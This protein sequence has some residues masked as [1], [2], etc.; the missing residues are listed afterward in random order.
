[1]DFFYTPY[2]GSEETLEETIRRIAA[3]KSPA[4]VINRQNNH[5]LFTSKTIFESYANEKYN[6]CNELNYTTALSI[7]DLAAVRLTI[8]FT[9]TVAGDLHGLFERLMDAAQLDYGFLY[10][11]RNEQSFPLVLIVTRHESLKYSIVGSNT[12]CVCT[13][14]DRHI[15]FEKKVDGTRCLCPAPHTYHCTQSQ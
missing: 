14:S 15:S 6:S 4:V 10:P 3:I 1:M 7:G 8:P 5:Y 13:G 2:V 9:V 11:D 12:I